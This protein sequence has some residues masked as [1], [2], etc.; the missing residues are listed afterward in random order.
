MP[1]ECLSNVPALAFGLP[2]GRI[3]GRQLRLVLG[4]AADVDILFK[5]MRPVL[6]G[7]TWMRIMALPSSRLMGLDVS[8]MPSGCSM[9]ANFD[10]VRSWADAEREADW[11]DEYALVMVRAR[12]DAFV[13]HAAGSVKSA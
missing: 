6:S 4:V 5:A 8:V 7:F 12:L 3:V 2:S 10:R 9:A 11:A 1:S 13:Q